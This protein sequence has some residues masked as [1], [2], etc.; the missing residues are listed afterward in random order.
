MVHNRVATNLENLSIP[1]FSG[2]LGDFSERGKLMEFSTNSVQPLKTE[3]RHW[4]YGSARY[5]ATLLCVGLYVT[6]SS[7]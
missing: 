4:L 2:I 7:A 6:V 3:W 1:G 5:E